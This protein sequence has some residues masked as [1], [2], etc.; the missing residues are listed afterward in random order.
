M[1]RRRSSRPCT[2]DSGTIPGSRWSTQAAGTSPSTWRASRAG[3]RH[4]TPRP[5]PPLARAA[6]A[7]VEP[8]P[9]PGRR[10]AP[11]G[12]PHRTRLRRGSLRR[13]PDGRSRRARHRRCARGHR[14]L[15]GEDLVAWAPRPPTSIVFSVQ[16]IGQGRRRRRCEP[17]PGAAVS[18]RNGR[19][20]IA[21]LRSRRVARV[22]RR[23]RRP[24]AAQSPF[25][26]GPRC[27]SQPIRADQVRGRLAYAGHVLR[28]WAPRC[29]TVSTPAADG[30]DAGS[31]PRRHPPI[32]RP[33][34]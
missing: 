1:P 11:A 10:D 17:A 12:P 6:D 14:S 22:R 27:V 4:P 29:S 9:D 31:R 32:V 23:P 16:G 26:W 2:I 7:R 21:T 8:A 18:P 13:C 24:A 25:A 20:P 34:H 33:L 15:A 28:R 5:D 19:G 3:R 30:G